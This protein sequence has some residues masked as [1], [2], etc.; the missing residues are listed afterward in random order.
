MDQP[1]VPPSLSLFLPNQPLTHAVNRDRY[2][3]QAFIKE[4]EKVTGRRVIVYMSSLNHS[5]SA[6]LREDIAPFNEI[7]ASI[8]KDSD[9][10]F[11]IQSPGGDPNA[12]EIIVHTLLSRTKHLRVVVPQA[13][14]S[15]ATL[16]S[17]AADEIVMSNT[18]ELG[19]IDPQVT[20]PTSFGLAFRPAQAFLNGLEMI[21]KEH[22]NGQALNPAYYPFLKGVDAALIDYCLKS[23]EHSKRLAV[24]WLSRSM[25]KGNLKEAQRIAEELINIEKYP[26][27]GQ[28]IDHFDAKSIGLKVVYKPYGDELWQAWWRLYVNY[29]VMM[30]EREV[31]KIFESSD[32][33]VML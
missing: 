27:H 7:I 13:A 5:D 25:H 31:V 14:K 12:A 1:Q 19:P 26:N 23:I 8:D 18:S 28:V 6:I 30:R 24:K 2:D 9:V 4:I 32:A 20:I 22:A 33:S 21:K 16:V 29:I 10:D 15:A 3:R 17:L 11:I